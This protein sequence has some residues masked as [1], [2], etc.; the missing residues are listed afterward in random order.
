MKKVRLQNLFSEWEK[1]I[2]PDDKVSA[3]LNLNMYLEGLAPVYESEY[4][5]LTKDGSYKWI[6]SRGKIIS[7]TT[8]G[9]PLRVTGTHSDINSRKL[10][11]QELREAKERFSNVLEYSQD[12][13]YRR[14]VVSDKYDYMSPVIER[15]TGYTLEEML[16][17]NEDDI[18]RKI[19]PDDLHNVVQRIK[20]VTTRNYVVQRQ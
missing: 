19:H 8:D 1:L 4:R 9:K 18:F 17:M 6:L 7:W 3:Y 20:E 12:A 15:L 14:N 5:L 11:E 10:M 13:S 2:H 16:V